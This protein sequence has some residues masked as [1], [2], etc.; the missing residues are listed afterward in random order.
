MQLAPAMFA[1]VLYVGCLHDCLIEDGPRRGFK[2]LGLPE[3][4]RQL[5]CPILAQC[6]PWRS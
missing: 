2:D 5:E 1:H 6:H 4:S 3:G